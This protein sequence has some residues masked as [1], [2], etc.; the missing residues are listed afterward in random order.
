MSVHNGFTIEVYGFTHSLRTFLAR[1]AQ[2]MGLHIVYVPL[3]SQPYL[4]C[5]L[6]TNI[7]S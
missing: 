2:Y 7:K 6:K 5:F 3:P 4:D 1:A